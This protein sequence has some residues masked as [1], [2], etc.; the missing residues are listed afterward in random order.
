MRMRRN[1]FFLTFE[2]AEQRRRQRSEMRWKE[3]RS[4]YRRVRH[5]SESISVKQ[6]IR[7]GTLIRRTVKQHILNI[8]LFIFFSFNLFIELR[9]IY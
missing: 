6:S 4:G 8:L 1:R 7:I 2:T 3:Y 9:R 5:G